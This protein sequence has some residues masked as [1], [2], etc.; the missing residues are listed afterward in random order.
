MEQPVNLSND[1]LRRITQLSIGHLG[2]QFYIVS[3][4]HHGRFCSY[5]KQ[6]ALTLCLEKLL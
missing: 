5:S 3:D 2:L 1:T 6:V 4:C